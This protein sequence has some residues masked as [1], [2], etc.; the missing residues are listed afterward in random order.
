[1][2]NYDINSNPALVKLMIENEKKAAKEYL[3]KNPDSLIPKFEQ[4][5]RDFG[6]E[7]GISSQTYSFMPK[8]KETILP[9]AIKYYQQAK[10]QLKD[11]EQNHFL[12]FFHSKGFEEV[13]PMLIEDF[14]SPSTQNPTRWFIADC[15][16]QIRSKKYI[17]DYLKI[18]SNS[19]YGMDRQM[20]VLLIGKLKVEKAIP[21]LINLL[22]DSDVTGHAI[23]A[24][25]QY[26][27][28]EIR[29]YFERFL[30]HKNSYYRREA[31]KAIKKLDTL[32]DPKK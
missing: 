28:E 15:L 6:L 5:L 32:K 16:Y 4:E 29:P 31:Q 3:E 10:K 9:L 2:S 21:V 14:H 22:D 12:K 19:A 17:D 1:M 7:F 27:R 23:N 20:I 25:S 30:N 26:K 18:I 8:H 11:N 24:L 13:I